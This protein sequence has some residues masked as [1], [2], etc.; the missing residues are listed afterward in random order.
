MKKI[1]IF[2]ALI[3]SLMI[4]TTMTYGMGRPHGH[5]YYVKHSK[6]H[7]SHKVHKPHGL[8]DATY[9]N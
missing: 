2:S 8:I 7:K 5:R 4:S 1:V 9:Q 3:M 6:H